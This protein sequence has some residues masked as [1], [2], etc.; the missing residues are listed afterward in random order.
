MHNAQEMFRLAFHG[1]AGDWRRDPG[2]T[3]YTAAH[4]RAG[5]LRPIP[6]ILDGELALLGRRVE[7]EFTPRA[8]RALA[9]PGVHGAVL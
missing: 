1:L 9:L 2:I 7:F 3:V 5:A 8:F 4:G 6:C